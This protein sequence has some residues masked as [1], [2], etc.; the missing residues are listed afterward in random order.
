MFSQAL[1]YRIYTLSL[2]SILV[3]VILFIVIVRLLSNHAK[4]QGDGTRRVLNQNRCCGC[5]WKWYDDTIQKAVLRLLGSDAEKR[6]N[7]FSRKKRTDVDEEWSGRVH[8]LQREMTRLAEESALTMG[9]NVKAIE[10]NVSSSET[11]LRSEV[12]TVEEHVAVL[13]TEIMNELRSSEQRMEEMMKQ[14]MNQLFQALAVE[15]KQE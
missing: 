8:F 5:I 13:K 3:N 11:R 6:S 10:Q 7:F 1:L 9:E 14:S 15:G 12:K 4:D 2:V